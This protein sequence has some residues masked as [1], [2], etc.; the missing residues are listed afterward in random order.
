MY[1]CPWCTIDSLYEE[2][3]D[4]EWGVPVYDDRKLFEF[5]ILESAQAGLSWI[6]IL[7]KRENY[8]KAYDNFNPEEVAKYDEKKVSELLNNKGLI[9]NKKK[10]Q[11]S[12]H[13][14]K[15]FLDIKSEFGT[16]NNYIWNFV[17]GKPIHN[18]WENVEQI[19]SHTKL[20]DKIYK[21]LRNRGFVFIGST[22]IYS[23]MQAVGIVNDHIVSC[24]RYE[25]IKKY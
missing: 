14:A 16:F 24:F 23:F 21:D 1:K 20:S 6:T 7:K 22:I 4:K 12:I 25:E 9:R 2:Y 17:D 13:N 5:L 10:I 8:R 19:P 15:K 11:A 3:H 18:K